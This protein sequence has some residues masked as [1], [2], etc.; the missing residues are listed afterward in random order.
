MNNLEERISINFLTN[1]NK[2]KRAVLWYMAGKKLGYSDALDYAL[3]K[4]YHIWG[5]DGVTESERKSF[6]LT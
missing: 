5:I 6:S 4:V 1:M 2:T 3:F